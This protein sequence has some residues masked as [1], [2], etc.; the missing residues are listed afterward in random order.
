VRELDIGFY[1]TAMRAYRLTSWIRLIAIFASINY[2]ISI[3]T[4]P[5][6]YET[7]NI[8]DIPTDVC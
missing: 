2:A 5:S 1:I 8:F 3:L 6:S 4:T 7:V